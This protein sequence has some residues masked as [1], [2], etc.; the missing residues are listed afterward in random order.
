VAITSGQTI[1]GTSATQ[2]D[3]SSANP[4]RLHI[5]NQDNTNSVFL[6]NISVTTSTGLQLLKLDSI[7]LELNPGEALYAVSAGGSHTVSFLRQTF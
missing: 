3:G 5:H 7:E 1:V 4:S 6:G 2:I